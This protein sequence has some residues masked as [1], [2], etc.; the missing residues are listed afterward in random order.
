MK[1]IKIDG[2]VAVME[3]AGDIKPKAKRLKYVAAAWLKS[4]NTMVA[5]KLPRHVNNAEAA[6]PIVSKDIGATPIAVHFSKSG[7]DVLQQPY[8]DN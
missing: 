5:V 3:F 6:T 8:G 7:C 1:T 2:P 4:G